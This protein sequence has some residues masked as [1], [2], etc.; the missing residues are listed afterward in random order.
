MTNQKG[1]YSLFPVQSFHYQVLIYIFCMQY[2]GVPSLTFLRVTISL[3]DQAYFLI[4]QSLLQVSLILW[5][6]RFT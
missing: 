3:I 1:L 4:V 6:Y 5:F 2:A